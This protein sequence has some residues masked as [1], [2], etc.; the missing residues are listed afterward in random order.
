M[1]NSK[2]IELY[3]TL[4]PIEKKRFTEYV[5]SPF[6]NSNTFVVKLLTYI[7]NRLELNKEAELDKKR[8]QVNVFGAGMKDEQKL[9]DIMTFL[10]R[11]LEA[12][13]AQLKF[14]KKK[15]LQKEFL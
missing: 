7:Q 11:L 2:L 1:N 15:L 13:M 5:E 3:K 12:F 6:F 9:S 14:D 4:S 10:M 8:A